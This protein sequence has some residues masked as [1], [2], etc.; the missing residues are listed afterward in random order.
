MTH[1][2]RELYR[3]RNTDI[4]FMRDTSYT[5]SRVFERC[6]T[7]C[8]SSDVAHK[9]HMV[10]RDTRQFSQSLSAIKHEVFFLND[11]STASYLRS[12]IIF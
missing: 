2:S 9:V 5:H 1:I 3:P 4:C 12:T 7:S 6:M 11:L 10:A 8:I